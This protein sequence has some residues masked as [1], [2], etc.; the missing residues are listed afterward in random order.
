VTLVLPHDGGT[1]FVFAQPVVPGLD[2]GRFQHMGGV[3]GWEHYFYEEDE[4]KI[5]TNAM[6]FDKIGGVVPFRQ[7]PPGMPS[8]CWVDN[9]TRYQTTEGFFWKW[10]QRDQ[11]TG[12][13]YPA[14][15]MPHTWLDVTY[16]PPILDPQEKVS[17]LLDSS[18]VANYMAEQE[19][20]DTGNAIRDWLQNETE[21]TGPNRGYTHLKDPISITPEGIA[22]NNFVLEVPND[23]L[24]FAPQDWR[25]PGWYR[26]FDLNGEELDSE[27]WLN[28]RPSGKYRIHLRPRLWRYTVTVIA[29]YV[30]VSLW[31]AIPND[32]IFIHLYY[33]RPPFYPHRHDVIHTKAAN[34]LFNFHGQPRSH[35]PAIDWSWE[36]SRA[37]ADLARQMLAQ[38]YNLISAVYIYVGNEDPDIF[39]EA[40]PSYKNDV[41]AVIERI[42][43]TTDTAQCVFV[44][45]AVNL[46]D[47]F[48]KFH[49]GSYLA[50]WQIT[51]PTRN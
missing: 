48:R 24:L 27:T 19:G 39:V 33:D 46:D 8:T 34:P 40:W 32:E 36:H 7:W 20:G 38:Q 23:Q 15:A 17:T 3:R 47:H 50:R 1:E 30:Y 16:E 10:H 41:V 43:E 11:L 6:M 13:Y 29:H 44:R 5:Q 22:G 42:D 35:D 12:S 25:E 2:T 28:L 45:Q 49:F 21:Y 18:E 4:Y 9:T 51:N 26:C 37:A 14:P 31:G